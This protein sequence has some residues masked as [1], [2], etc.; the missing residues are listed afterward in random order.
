M[1]TKIDRNLLHNLFASYKYMKKKSIIVTK[2]LSVYKENY[3]K[4]CVPFNTH[5]NNF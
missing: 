2:L 1:K 4:L 5:F 3:F